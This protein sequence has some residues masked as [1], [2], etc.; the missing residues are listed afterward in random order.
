MISKSVVSW[1]TQYQLPSAL[2]EY[3]K[4][5]YFKNIRKMEKSSTQNPHPHQMRKH[6]R[7]ALLSLQKGTDAFS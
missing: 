7:R 3:K 5:R 2:V 1:V 6:Y 4:S